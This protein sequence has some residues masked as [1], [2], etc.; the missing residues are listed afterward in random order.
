MTLKMEK[1]RRKATREFESERE[2][3]PESK[4]ALLSL[5]IP[6]LIKKKIRDCYF[7]FLNGFFV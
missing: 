1:V 3:Q 2:R 4:A 6:F 7:L 5:L